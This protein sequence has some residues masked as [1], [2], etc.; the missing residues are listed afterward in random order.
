VPT[1]RVAYEPNSLDPAVPRE[2][3]E[4]G[5][6]TYADQESGDKLRA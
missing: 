4:R 1:G 2:S 6:A 5:F 3:A